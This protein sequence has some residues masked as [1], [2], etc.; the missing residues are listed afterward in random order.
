L[1]GGHTNYEDD[2]LDVFQYFTVSC[3]RGYD[4]EKDSFYAVYAEVFDKI[5]SEDI[6]YMDTPEEY[7]EIPKFGTSKSSYEDVVGRFYAYW[8]AY[9]TKKSKLVF[10]C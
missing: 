4:D 7:D 3:Y 10:F 1:K 6:E 5:A 9:S 2:S 8:E